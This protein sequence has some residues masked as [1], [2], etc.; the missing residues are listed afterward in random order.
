M[1]S[2][3]IEEPEVTFKMQRLKLI[4]RRWVIRFNGGERSLAW[5]PGLVWLGVGLWAA[6]VS[7][8]TTTEQGLKTLA[9]AVIEIF[10]AKCSQCHAPESDKR[11]AKKRWADSHDLAELV[12]RYVEPDSATA[13]GYE[14]TTLWLI[15]TDDPQRRMPPPK[16]K[17]GQLTTSELETVGRWIAAG[18]PM[19]PAVPAIDSQSDSF[20]TVSESDERIFSRRLQRWLGRLHPAMVHLPIGLL[21]AAAMAEWLWWM[22]GRESLDYVSRFCTVIGAAGA[23]PAA[24]MGWMAGSFESD[25]DPT[26]TIHRWMGVAVAGLAVVTAWLCIASAYP[27]EQPT[28]RRRLTVR[29]LVTI[30]AILVSMTGHFGGVLVHGHDYLT[31]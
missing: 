18:T 7:I 4:F 13:E 14:D 19:V 31:W 3:L 25:T 17:S 5:L 21:L 24:A 29:W 28:T 1:I 16:S 11:S 26:L 23:I 22:T 12:K 30:N 9:P 2:N 27:P 15:L 6:Q 10:D 8:A 20:P